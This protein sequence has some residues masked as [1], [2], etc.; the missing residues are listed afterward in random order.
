MF[1][2]E[3]QAEKGN[4]QEAETLWTQA[5]AGGDA[6]C[7]CQ[8]DGQH[9]SSPGRDRS[10]VLPSFPAVS[11]RGGGVLAAY[12]GVFGGI[13]CLEKDTNRGADGSASN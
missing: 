11:C 1:C 3:S 13:F 8:Q 4:L 6:S 9:S 2:W 12:V 5:L 7:L 10:L